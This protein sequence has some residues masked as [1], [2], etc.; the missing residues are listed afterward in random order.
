MNARNSALRAGSPR[1][2]TVLSRHA[3]HL[4]RWERAFV[5]PF[6]RIA[7][8]HKGHFL[9]LEDLF[10][11]IDQAN[12]KSQAPRRINAR[13]ANHTPTHKT[14]VSLTADLRHTFLYLTRLSEAHRLP[15]AERTAAGTA[16]ATAKAA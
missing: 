16:A 3:S 2:A 14:P 7:R 4:H 10:L 6:L 12:P 8:P 9:A 13:L 15:P 11:L 1:S 5:N